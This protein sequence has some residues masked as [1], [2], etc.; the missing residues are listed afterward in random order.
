MELGT[1][2]FV[3]AAAVSPKHAANL[4]SFATV[5][6]TMSS[7]PHAGKDTEDHFTSNT[8]MEVREGECNQ[9]DLPR[10][11]A[12][13]HAGKDTEDHFTSPDSMVL[14]DGEGNQT[15][16]HVYNSRHAGKDTDDH[17]AEGGMTLSPR[18]DEGGA[19][20]VYASRHAGKDTADHFA[21]DGMTM[22]AGAD[23]GDVPCVYG[24]AHAGKDTEDHF[25]SNDG[26]TLR[27]DADSGNAFDRVYSTAHEGKDTEDHFG[28]PGDMT[29]RADADA[30][31]AFDRVYG[32]AH[33]N[34]DTEDHFVAGTLNVDTGGSFAHLMDPNRPQLKAYSLEELRP[35]TRA[36]FMRPANLSPE[37]QAHMDEIVVKQPRAPA[38]APASGS[39]VPPLTKQMAQARAALTSPPGG[40]GG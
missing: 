27:D 16:P 8:S 35:P 26:M 1:R 3:I 18:A 25:T 23:D 12:A 2:S 6:T 13:K 31:M 10:V 30:G 37:M 28:S 7:A 15:L 17:F 22:S 24:K 32:T 11:Y 20:K 4:G 9:Q 40:G 38:A 14:R 19:P 33:V 39:P 29:L 34:K 36:K 5:E 21:A